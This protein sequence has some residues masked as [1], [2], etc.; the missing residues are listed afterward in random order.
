MGEVEGEKKKEVGKQ[1]KSVH[2][3]WKPLFLPCSKAGRIRKYH[4]VR[5]I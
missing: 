3:M 1:R 2:S 4:S 5:V